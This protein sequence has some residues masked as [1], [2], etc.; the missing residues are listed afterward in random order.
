MAKRD[1]DGALWTDF[2]DARSDLR[3][4]TYNSF[5][6]EDIQLETAEIMAHDEDYFLH[7]GPAQRL[8]LV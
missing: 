5:D 8:G 7:H 1:H 6:A 4:N 2:V 3:Q